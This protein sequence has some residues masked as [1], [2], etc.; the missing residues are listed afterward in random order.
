MGGLKFNIRASEGEKRNG[1]K[2]RLYAGH[3]N[4]GSVSLSLNLGSQMEPNSPYIRPAK[5]LITASEAFFVTT[6]FLTTSDLR[7]T[8]RPRQLPSPSPRSIQ[9]QC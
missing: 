2:M 1:Q 9:C 5:I 8:Y 7:K 6:A 4:Y 3:L